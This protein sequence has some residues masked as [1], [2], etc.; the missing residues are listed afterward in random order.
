MVPAVDGMGVGVG[1]VFGGDVDDSGLG[2]DH[3]FGPR[4]L[5]ELAG[6][7]EG[8]GGETEKQDGER[9]QDAFHGNKIHGEGGRF[10]MEG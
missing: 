6:D 9:Q 3:L 2:G 7:E 1:L 5:L 4:G 8:G 10:K